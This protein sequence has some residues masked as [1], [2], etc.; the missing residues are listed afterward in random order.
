M[1]LPADENVPLPVTREL[2]TDGHD[3]VETARERDDWRGHF[4]VIEQ[5]R[6]RMRPF[7]DG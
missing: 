7:P 6:I 1:R 4:A 3:V 5:Q 2:R